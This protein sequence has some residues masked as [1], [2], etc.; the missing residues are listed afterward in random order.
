MIFSEKLASLLLSR[1]LDSL[2]SQFRKIAR[3]LEYPDERVLMQR[4][5]VILLDFSNLINGLLKEFLLGHIRN[6]NFLDFRHMVLCTRLPLLDRVIQE[7]DG[8]PQLVHINLNG[9]FRSLHVEGQLLVAIAVHGRVQRLEHLQ[10][11]FEHLASHRV[12]DDVNT[13]LA[14]IQL[15][16]HELHHGLHFEQLLHEAEVAHLL[17][18][19]IVLDRCTEKHRCRLL[20]I[21]PKC[22]ISALCNQVVQN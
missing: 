22:V 6:I 1:R 2:G 7:S 18:V 10:F 17:D 21:Q 11:I 13:G 8:L 16:R 4:L 15:R 12:L 9:L 14:L 20:E 19:V 3:V 5:V